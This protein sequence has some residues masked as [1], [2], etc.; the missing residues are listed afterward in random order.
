[1]LSVT[2]YHHLHALGKPSAVAIPY[3]TKIGKRFFSQ[4]RNDQ[5]AKD[6]KLVHCKIEDLDIKLPFAWLFGDR[7]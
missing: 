3:S 1:V 5:P 4:G 6:L 7:L 2:I